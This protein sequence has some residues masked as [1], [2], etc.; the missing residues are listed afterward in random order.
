VDEEGGNQVDE[1]QARDKDP[2]PHSPLIRVVLPQTPLV[3]GKVSILDA[4][5]LLRLKKPKYV[6]E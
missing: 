2:D 1:S 3:H 6:L 4:I 5:T